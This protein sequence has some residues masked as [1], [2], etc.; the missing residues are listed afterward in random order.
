MNEAEAA[1]LQFLL[2]RL[3]ALSDEHWHTFTASRRAMDDH[4]WVGGT[5]ARDFARRLESSD[6]ALHAELR[7]A[8]GLVE[9]A[10]RRA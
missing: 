7:K 3:R 9:D 1:R 8:L 5:S 6:S 10:L 4:A 2:A